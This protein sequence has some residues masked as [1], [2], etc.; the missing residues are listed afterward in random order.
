[1]SNYPPLSLKTKYARTPRAP[2]NRSHFLGPRDADPSTVLGFNTTADGSPYWVEVGTEHGPPQ[3]TGSTQEV[4]LSGEP[5]L[6]LHVLII[7]L[8]RL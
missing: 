2:H 1:M 8:S 7:C 3:S 4:K 6:L 5:N